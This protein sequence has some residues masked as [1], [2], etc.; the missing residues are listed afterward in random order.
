[1][2]R[3]NGMCKNLQ[4]N[5]FPN[6]IKDVRPTYGNKEELAPLSMLFP[7]TEEQ[8]N[9]KYQRSLHNVVKG[10]CSY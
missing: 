4:I 2:K 3:Y 6:V 7:S 8:Q 1:M 9:D 10:V 5:F